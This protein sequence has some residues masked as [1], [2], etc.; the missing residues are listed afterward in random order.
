MVISNFKHFWG[1]ICLKF[2]QYL[3]YKKFLFALIKKDYQV[4][5]GRKAIEI[6]VPLNLSFD[7]LCND[8]IA[9]SLSFL[10][11]VL[12]LQHV[13]VRKSFPASIYPKRNFLFF[14]QAKKY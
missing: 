10:Y 7:L 6:L 12:R 13:R 11:V 5:L 1:Q 9:C 14:Y 2:N 8:I 4:V 3:N